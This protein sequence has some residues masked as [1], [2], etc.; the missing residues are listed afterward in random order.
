MTQEAAKAALITLATDNPKAFADFPP[1]PEL[2]K[3]LPILPEE[4]G[5]L[6]FGAFTVDTERLWYSADIQWRGGMHSYNGGFV[7]RDGRWLAEPP[8]LLRF[9]NPR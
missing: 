8:E 6:G 2:L 4:D 1:D 3:G 9:H 7:F 5:K